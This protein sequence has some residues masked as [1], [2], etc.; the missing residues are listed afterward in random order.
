MCE[1]VYC[2][3]S[4]EAGSRCR[5]GWPQRHFGADNDDAFLILL[6]SLAESWRYAC[7][8]TLSLGAE[9]GTEPRLHAC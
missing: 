2:Y 5:A 9:D 6:P 4:F 1:F 8:T 3:F 7:A